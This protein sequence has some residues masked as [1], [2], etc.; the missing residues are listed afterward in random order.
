MHYTTNILDVSPQVA[1]NCAYSAL[2]S[3]ENPT[4][5]TDSSSKVVIIPSLLTVRVTVGYILMSEIVCLLTVKPMD[6]THCCLHIYADL[7]PSH[8][9]ESFSLLFL[10][11]FLEQFNGFLT[12]SNA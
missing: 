7:F 9:D 5:K 12:Q 1:Y 11:D 3:F 6:E 4:I 8:G 2:M 10:G